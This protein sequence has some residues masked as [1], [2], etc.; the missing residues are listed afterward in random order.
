MVLQSKNEMGI[1]SDKSAITNVVAN[2][3]LD[4][5]EKKKWNAQLNGVVNLKKN[6]NGIK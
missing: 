2:L 3:K 1:W 5:K 4:K 6:N